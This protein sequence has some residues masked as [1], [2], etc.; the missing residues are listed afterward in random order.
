MRHDGRPIGDRVIASAILD[1]LLHHAITLSIRGQ[2][3]RLKEKLKAG[4][5]KPAVT[6]GPPEGAPQAAVEERIDAA[7]DDDLFDFIDQ[8]FGSA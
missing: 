8:Q 4:L 6:T 5:V 7:S 1:R 3:Y 2:S